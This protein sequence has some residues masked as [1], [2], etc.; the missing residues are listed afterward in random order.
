MVVEFEFE[1]RMSGVECRVCPKARRSSS[2]LPCSKGAALALALALSLAL[3]LAQTSS[4]VNA[5]CEGSLIHLLPSYPVLPSF[6]A[7]PS[8]P[9]FPAFHSQ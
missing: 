9:S 4:L 2:D 1:C 7:F 5:A 3:A 6:P 8:F